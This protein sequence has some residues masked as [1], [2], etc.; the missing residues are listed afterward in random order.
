MN[1]I[2]F[3]RILIIV[4]VMLVGVGVVSAQP[5][6]DVKPVP[7]G[8]AVIGENRAGFDAG[9]SNTWTYE[10]T[11]GEIL[12]VI[13]EAQKPANKADQETRDEERLLDTEVFVYAP[14]GDL[15]GSNDDMVDAVLTNSFLRYVELK[16]TGTYTIEVTNW[17]REEG[18]E[19]EG[20]YTLILH[21]NKNR[22]AERV[23]LPRIVSEITTATEVMDTLTTIIEEFDTNTVLLVNPTYCTITDATFGDLE[24][25]LEPYSGIIVEVPKGWYSL[26]GEGDVCELNGDELNVPRE[27]VIM[28]T[29]F[30]DLADRPEDSQF[31]TDAD[32]LANS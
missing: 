21:S 5:T 23:I 20:R 19:T 1:K 9:G 10:G 8:E 22:R 29:R 17:F 26:R 16:T 6:G 25:D 32:A 4:L 30:D 18:D 28:V 31:P 3:S 13:V 15:L 2:Y 14:D 27:T 7:K 11:E 24:F 12:T